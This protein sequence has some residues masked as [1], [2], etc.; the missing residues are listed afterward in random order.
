MVRAAG[1]LSLAIPVSMSLFAQEWVEISPE[2]AATHLVKK[3]EPVYPT[4]AKSAGVE[5]VVRIEIGISKDG[6]ISTVAGKTGPPSLYKAA[7]DAL[8]RYRYRPFVRDGHPVNVTTAANFIFQLVSHQNMEQLYP[9][10]NLTSKSFA[11]FESHR[12]TTQYSDSLQKWLKEDLR[13]QNKEMACGDPG[14]AYDTDV[15]QLG[16]GDRD[17]HLYLVARQKKCLCGATG[18]CPLELVEENKSGIRQVAAASGWGVALDLR[19]GASSPDVF[20][21][22]NMGG[23]Q[24]NVAGFIK[25]AGE[26]G[27]L[28]CG[29]INSSLDSGTGEKDDVHICH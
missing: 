12:S 1:S 6:T 28:Y 4:F 23:G 9:N 15:F 2:V 19:N 22:S 21:I 11:F 29:Q 25:A 7:E 3:L 18:N 8:L 17:D 24:S 27:Q 16:L 20:F 10:P 14:L 26:W 5:G 13:K